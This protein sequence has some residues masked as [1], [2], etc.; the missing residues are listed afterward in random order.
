MNPVIQNLA[1]ELA[2]YINAKVN[3]PW[4][5]EEQEQAFFELVVTKVLDLIMGR[6]LDQLEKKEGSE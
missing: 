4:M 1:K 2:D 3:L 6:V 5:N